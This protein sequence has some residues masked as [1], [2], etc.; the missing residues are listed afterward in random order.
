MQLA[1]CAHQDN[2]EAISADHDADGADAGAEESDGSDADIGEEDPA[3]VAADRGDMA[4]SDADG[5]G[6]EV[7]S[8][9]LDS[10]PDVEA[11]LLVRLVD[12]HASTVADIEKARA[13]AEKYSRD[14]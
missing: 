3:A 12:D 10:F 6:D 14:C 5:D 13:L 1:N 8:H 11:D 7:A 4:E 2:V 9:Y